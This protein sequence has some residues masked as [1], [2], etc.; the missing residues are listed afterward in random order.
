[1]RAVRCALSLCAA[2]APL[3]GLVACDGSTAGEGEGE[4]TD[5]GIPIIV[6]DAGPVVDPVDGGPT[7]AGPI[8]TAVVINALSPASGPLAGGGRVIVEGDGF[9]PSC[10]LSF[11]EVVA[12][13]ALCLLLT[14]RSFSCQLPA[15][16]EP[17]SVDVTISCASGVGQLEGGFTYFS[18][19]S[20]AGISPTTGPTEGGTD[21][22]LTGGSFTS[23]MVATIGGRHVVNLTI[24]EDGLS[25]TAK[26]P[27]GAGRAD[28]VVI[29]AFGRSTLPLAFS[30]TS[31]LALDAV[32]PSVASPGDVVELLGSG[33]AESNG[34]VVAAEVADTVAS[35]N[36]LISD[37][38][39]RV[40]VPAVPAGLQDVGVRRNAETVS[41]NDA[42]VVLGD[43]TGSFAVT[44]VVPTTAD[45]GGGDVV[46]VVGEGF[47]TATSV[48]FD[49]VLGT[50]LVVVND[51]QLRVTA[52]AHASGAVDVVVALADTSTSTLTSALTYLEQVR[53]QTVSP[54]SADAA[55]GVEVTVTGA[56]F[57][58]TT[59]VTFGGIACA[60]VVVVDSTT[61]TCTL[62][63]GAAGSVDVVVQSSTGTAR[64]TEGFVFETA[65]R[66][67]GIVPVR[68][69][70]AGDVVVSVAG[71]GFERLAR[72]STTTNPLLVLIGGQPCDPRETVVVSDNL[73]RTR[74]PLTDLGVLD[75]T[76][77]LATI[78]VDGASVSV[79]MS[80]TEVATA[81]RVYTTF[82]PVSFLGG[83]RGGPVQ[84]TMY[85]SA[86]DATTGLPIPNALAF[87]GDDVPTAADITHEFGT[88]TLSGPE[89][90]G[91]QTVTVAADGYE[92]ASLIDVDAQEVTFRLR[93]LAGGGGGGGGGGEFPPPA[94]VRGRVF[95]FAKEFFD[96]AAL[97][98]DEIALAIVQTTESRMFAPAD[99]PRPST[100]VFEEGG[101]Y[102]LTGTRTGRL[103][104][105]A[106]AGIF[107]LTTQ[108]FRPRQ[109][110]FR[111]EVFPSP[112]VTLI[113]QDIELTVDLDNTIQLSMPDAPL[114]NEITDVRATTN[115][116]DITRVVPFIN[117]GGEG[118]FF[119]TQAFAGTRNHA[120]EGM[121]QLPGEMLTFFAG[122][123]TTTGSFG[124][125]QGG[126]Y[127]N[128]GTASLTANSVTVTGQN[129][130]NTWSA[131]EFGQPA[132]LGQV[133]VTTLPDGKKFASDIMGV[134][135]DGSLRLR[136]RAPVTAA[137][138]A[139]HI[140]SPRPSSSEVIQDGVGNLRGGVTI[141]PVL[142]IPELVTPQNGAPLTQRTIRWQAQPGEQPTLHTIELSNK[143][144]PP[145]T[146]PTQRWTLTIEGS[147]SKVPIPT[148]PELAVFQP[149]LPIAEQTLPD[150]FIPPEDLKV[151][152]FFMTHT[153]LYVP[154][155][156]YRN[157]SALDTSLL[158]RRSWTTKRTTLVY[159]GDR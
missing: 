8:N 134:A 88:A 17:G 23:G 27:P 22:V 55:G 133:F 97:N 48:S 116:P 74:S 2:F 129:N 85:V 35:R 60:D 145:A 102:A 20:L 26:T 66:V 64:L 124:P 30:F 61:L 126:L 84:G 136:D 7:D 41:L 25:A 14:T 44:A 151:G 100:T 51:R 110:G 77:G 107:N 82:N 73:I 87:T 34:V 42:L 79:T 137:G 154:N 91:A 93:P 101:E 109:L 138:L 31:S 108:E 115:G 18:P 33:F 4:S 68:G 111:R 46:T 113:D 29:D 78:T 130:Q 36:N 16:V 157:W 149:L 40:V 106:I 43:P 1:M 89:I 96:P 139:Y 45:V 120:L 80:D 6:F 10:T 159:G 75:V 12:D 117:L 90:F 125:G 99:E 3:S 15:G 122:A 104:M 103:A 131:T 67:L 83:P 114:D 58:A 52:P 119:Y 144:A 53:V 57:D 95:G 56:G 72:L 132:V 38:R 140:G 143:V 105:V 69:S 37:R 155:L 142:G 98:A 76:V 39:Q 135:P 128:A 70:F 153:A 152:G 28:V 13:P 65:P 148:V 19:I 49:G 141:Q 86:I 118:S 158:G 146:R 156:D 81:S 121:P 11:G 147:R 21:I 63:A 9:D 71:A 94:V 59:T 50:D 5:A 32:T 92:T 150:T 54:V 24:A 62:G 47:A 123:Y 127:S 112:G